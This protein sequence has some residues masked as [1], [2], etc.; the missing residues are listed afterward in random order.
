MW[1]RPRSWRRAILHRPRMEREMDAEL[2]FHIEAYA[3]DL[4]RGGVPRDEALRRARIAFGGI[5][6]A[7]EECRDAT[8]VNF[9]DSFMQDIR[10]A[11][12]MFRTSPGFAIAAVSTVALGIGHFSLQP[13]S[14]RQPHLSICSGMAHERCV[15]SVV[16]ARPPRN[17]RRPMVALR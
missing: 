2:R 10:F 13:P 11:L 7:K 3:D 6:R 8:G 9:L 15:R 12:R 4:V 1:T 5:E 17:A 14:S 16:D